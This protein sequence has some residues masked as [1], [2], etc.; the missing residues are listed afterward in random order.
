MR[1]GIYIPPGVV[2]AAVALGAIAVIAAMI[3]EMPEIQ[4]YIKT[5]TM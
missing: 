3:R 1:K 2:R 4:R 5:E